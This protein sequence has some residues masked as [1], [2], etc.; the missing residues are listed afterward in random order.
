[1][2]NEKSLALTL[3]PAVSCKLE[4]DGRQEEMVLVPRV[5]QVGFWLWNQADSGIEGP[6]FRIALTPDRL[7][8]LLASQDGRPFLVALS[9]SGFGT[10]AALNG[11]PA[12]DLG[13]W[14][15]PIT[16]LKF[17][18]EREPGAT[19]FIFEGST[20][21]VDPKTV[22]HPQLAGRFDPYQFRLSFEIRD[23]NMRHY[24]GDETARAAIQDY[25]AAW[26]LRQGPP[27]SSG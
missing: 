9:F 11:Y 1:M 22:L 20:G 24:V 17:G 10:V 7:S 21:P 4:I 26:R 12:A 14:T 8:D 13:S 25:T 27:E 19:L 3:H 15:R 6:H 2:S 18:A 5:D 16:A 23:E